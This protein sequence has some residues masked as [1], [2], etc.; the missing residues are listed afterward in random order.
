VFTQLEEHLITE[1]TCLRSHELKVFHLVSAHTG[2]PPGDYESMPRTTALATKNT[3]GRDVP[4]AMT[5]AGPAA[6]RRVV[7]K[8]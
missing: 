4:V 1:I 7:M 3:Q 2:S 8:P 6:P 5:L